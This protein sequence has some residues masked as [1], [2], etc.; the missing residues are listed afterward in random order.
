VK[1]EPPVAVAVIL[2]FVPP[3]V[4][5]LTVVA[6]TATVTP[7]QGLGGVGVLVLPQEPLIKRKEAKIATSC[8]ITL[9]IFI[10][11]FSFQ[12]LKIYYGLPL[13]QPEAY[14]SFVFF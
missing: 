6:V 13:V 9:K 10:R 8:A 14:F 7:L 12:S 11:S 3:T 2:P 1:P 4:V 5:G